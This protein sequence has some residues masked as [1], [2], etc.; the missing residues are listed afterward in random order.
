MVIAAAVVL[1][2]PD[3]ARAQGTLILPETRPWL[4]GPI[5]V[6]PTIAVRDVGTDSN[7][8]NDFSA[9][10]GDFTYAITPR[11]YVVAPLATSRF[12][13]RVLGDLVYYRIYEDQRSLSVVVDGR[14]EV[15]SPG[16]R[17]FASVGMASQHERHGFEIDSRARRTR[18]NAAAGADIDIT[19]ITAIA[20]WARREVTAW[21][22]DDVFE[23]VSLAEQLNH[24]SFSAAGGLR[25]RVTPLTTI[26]AEAEVKQD[27]FD[28]SPLR[29][30]S[31]ILVGPSVDFDTSAAIIGQV[32]VGYRVFRPLHANL[33]HYQG[34][35]ASVRLRYRL[36]EAA[37]FEFDWDRDVEYSY[38]PTTPYYLENGG[39]LVVT[40]HLVG[41][42][43]AVAIGERR[44]LRHQR[45]GERSFTGSHENTDTLGGG[46]SIQKGRQVRFTLLY[47]LTRR[48]S[49]LSFARE[50]ERHRI[51]GSMS[52]GL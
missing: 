24:T 9:P 51:R 2:V 19:A 28:H 48:A 47:E 30:S 25:F 18:T 49:N 43:N 1:L 31:S 41:P 44:T 46:V 50:F 5:S 13:T 21:S 14:Y 38:N 32:K 39:R 8:Y 23:G 20:V 15:L 36:R 17:P 7:V 33:A 52:Y 12:V 29:D 34:V 42:V 37:E 22:S 4:A 6:Y 10:R 35:A 27:R 40:Q 11:F 45:I 26:T 3:G 16:F